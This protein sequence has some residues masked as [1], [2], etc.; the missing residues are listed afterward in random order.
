MTI[1]DSQKSLLQTLE[2][3][4]R[5]LLNLSD[6]NYLTKLNKDKKYSSLLKSLFDILDKINII[7][8][9]SCSFI[10]LLIVVCDYIQYPEFKQK[11]HMISFKKIE[12]TYI[13][14]GVFLCH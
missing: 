7:K 2:I 13:K 5:N 4:L 11:L 12:N 1:L 8:N 9:F 14:K 6:P 3:D 10:N